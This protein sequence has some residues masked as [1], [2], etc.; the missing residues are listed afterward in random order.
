MEDKNNLNEALT[1]DS[2]S[3]QEGDKIEREYLP[4]HGEGDNM[5]SQAVTASTKLIYK[6]FNDGDIFD[7]T[8]GLEM[9]FNDLSSY[10]NWLYKYIPE[11]KNI[12]DK[13]YEAYIEKD[14]TELLYDLY[15]TIYTE[16]MADKY[17]SKNA[18]GSIY[19]C[20]GPFECVEPEGDELDYYDDYEDEE[21]IDESL[22]EETHAKYSKPE[23][24]KIKSFNNALKYAKKENKPFIYGY[25]NST[26][27]FFA[28]DQPIKCTD[29]DAQIKEF[30]NKYKN[31][32]VVYVAYPDKEFIKED[33]K[34]D[35]ESAEICDLLTQLNYYATH[36]EPLNLKLANDILKEDIEPVST[37]CLPDWEKKKQRTL[38]Y[39]N[40]IKDWA[41]KDAINNTSCK[42]NVGVDQLNEW[43]EGENK[44]D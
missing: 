14:Y 40:K 32:I 9:G 33:L 5:M 16:K 35:Y 18:I 25:T 8:S 24:D 20:D 37:E 22:K 29:L 28:I 19:E 27:K 6:W 26:G 23:G 4:Y 36:D 17:S 11:V 15:Q 13:V 39:Y 30:K 12:L 21:D 2:F 3:S 1:W 31:S 7:T 41:G 38:N 42:F 43:I 10:A 34:E 44:N